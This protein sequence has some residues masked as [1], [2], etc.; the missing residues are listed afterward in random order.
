MAETLTEHGLTLKAQRDAMR[1][2]KILGWECTA[3]RHRAITPTAR[4][5]KCGSDKVTTAT[6]AN[7]GKV[8][9]F[10]IQTVASEQFLNEVPFA[11]VVVELD[12][13]P[14]VSGWVPF[15]SRPGDLPVGQRVRFTPSYKPGM[16]FEKT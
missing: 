10:T 14:R 16:M 4:C 15:V 8:V 11:W 9:T 1:E 6:F 3:C 12:G 5:A 13:G 7:D 2:G